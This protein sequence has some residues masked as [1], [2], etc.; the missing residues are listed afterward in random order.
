MVLVIG[1]YGC[2]DINCPEC[3]T[4]L[5]FD[6]IADI[7]GQYPCPNCGVCLKTECRIIYIVKAVEESKNE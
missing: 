1:P 5:D 3:G 7:Y 6:D 4:D 2:G